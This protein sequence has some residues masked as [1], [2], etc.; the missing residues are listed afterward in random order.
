[1]ATQTSFNKFLSNIE[2]SNSTVDYISSVQTNL[3]DYL[4]SHDIY[5]KVFI[6][7][8]LSGSYAKHTS[9]RPV[10]NSSKR[11]VD[12]IIVTNHDKSEDSSK[13]LNELKNVLTESSK[14]SS[15][16]VQHHSVGV[17]LADISIDVVPAI[18]DE[19]DSSLYYICD[20]KS[21][22][23]IL[24]DPK[25]HKEWS[26]EINK[27]KNEKY[28]PLVKIFKWW[29]FKNCPTSIKYPKGITLEKIIADNIG[30]SVLSTEELL[31]ETIQNIITN[32]KEDY[33]DK[34]ILPVI[35]D[36]STKIE[37]NDLLEG[38]LFS[39]FS[40]FIKN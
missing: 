37:E 23:W 21:G 27:N 19:D 8:F 9:I 34:G 2:P 4:K 32:Y 10:K 33:V 25:G 28:K 24:S 13:V 3:R 22:D 1:M 31:I 7:S 5:K 15:A 14:Y 11:D 36:P 40:A 17:E 39:S 20:S 30:D 29:R 16:I 26:T 6:D 38:Y 35:E 18:E 12:I